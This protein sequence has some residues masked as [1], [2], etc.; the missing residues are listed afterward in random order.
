[1]AEVAERDGI[2]IN[3][4]L[5]FVI[6]CAKW[7]PSQTNLFINSYQGKDIGIKGITEITKGITIPLYRERERESNTAEQ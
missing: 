2:V 6:I 3:Y 5:T 1:M 4:N 7:L